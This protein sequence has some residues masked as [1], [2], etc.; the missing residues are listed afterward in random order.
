MRQKSRFPVCRAARSSAVVVPE[1]VFSETH[2]SAL[3]AHPGIKALRQPLTDDPLQRS[4]IHRHTPYPDFLEQFLSQH[5]ASLKNI[6]EVKITALTKEVISIRPALPDGRDKALDDMRVNQAALILET[7]AKDQTQ[8][9]EALAA[10]ILRLTEKAPNGKH[11]EKRVNDY[12]GLPQQS[13]PEPAT[14][15]AVPAAVKIKKAKPVKAEKPAI[16]PKHR[17]VSSKQPPD[18]KPMT[19]VEPVHVQGLVIGEDLSR[20]VSCYDI[21]DTDLKCLEYTLLVPDAQQMMGKVFDDRYLAQTKTYEQDPYAAIAM[22]EAHLEKLYGVSTLQQ[23]YF[24]TSDYK[25]ALTVRFTFDPQDPGQSYRATLLPTLAKIEDIIPYELA[26]AN[27]DERKRKKILGALPEDQRLDA[28]DHFKADLLAAIPSCGQLDG[29]YKFF[30]KRELISATKARDKV[31]YEKGVFSFQTLMKEMDI[32]AHHAA[33]DYIFDKKV[34]VLLRVDKEHYPRQSYEPYVRF[35]STAAADEKRIA[36][37]NC[38]LHLGM[39]KGASLY[40]GE[41]LRTFLLNGER[42]TKTVCDRLGIVH[43]R[44]VDLTTK[45]ARLSAPHPV[46]AVHIIRRIVPSYTPKAKAPRP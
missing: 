32:M 21:P 23:L 29:I 13:T 10:I 22:Q 41:A 18:L 46:A 27:F 45:P 20:L 8:S 11:I 39:D 42:L 24:S 6:F 31:E 25:P 2:F 40:S 9:K 14:R 3:T 30:D 36:R 44:Q 19:L 5:R 26:D 12:F 16:K 35:I 1:P 7:A 28:F 33:R 43:Q 15:P 37:D 4:E 17:Q 38:R 34:N